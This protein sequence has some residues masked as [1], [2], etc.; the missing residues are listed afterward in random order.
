[1]ITYAD[2]TEERATE[3]KLRENEERYSR[4]SEIGRASCRERV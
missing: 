3:R 1:M 4:V 2:V